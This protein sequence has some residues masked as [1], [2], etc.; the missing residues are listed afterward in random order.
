MTANVNAVGVSENVQQFVVYA[1]V[2]PASMATTA[3]STLSVS[4]DG[5]GIGDSIQAVA[6]YDMQS[7]IADCRPSGE[8][9]V[10]LSFYNASAGTVNLASGTWKFIVTRAG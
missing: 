9:T 6:P 5:V 4:L 7:I 3:D 8:G 1:V 10:D 2:D